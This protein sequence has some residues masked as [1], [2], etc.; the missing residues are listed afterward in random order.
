MTYLLQ[1]LVLITFVAGL[2]KGLSEQ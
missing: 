2:I 1:I